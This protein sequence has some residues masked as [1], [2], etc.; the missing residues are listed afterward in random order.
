[1]EQKKEVLRLGE[2][3]LKRDL[4]QVLELMNMANRYRDFG[5]TKAYALERQARELVQSMLERCE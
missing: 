5:D 3:E 4:Q 2:P 1:M